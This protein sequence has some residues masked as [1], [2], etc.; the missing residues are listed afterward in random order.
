LSATFPSLR[1]AS[2][3]RNPILVA[4]LVAVATAVLGGLLTNLGPWYFSLKQPTWKPPDW[5]FGP[6]WTLIFAC[7]AASAVFGWWAA[8][9]TGKRTMVTVLFCA[10]VVCNSLWSLLFF[11]LQRPDWALIEVAFLWLSIVV[12][13]WYLWPLSRRATLLLV[14]YLLWVTFA[15]NLNWAIVK[16]NAP[17]AGL[18]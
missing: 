6:A 12:L 2:E 7:T 4:T 16:M 10:N 5:A 17:F 1:T 15:A 14:P 3:T 9:G 11:Y 8:R 18:Q 13:M